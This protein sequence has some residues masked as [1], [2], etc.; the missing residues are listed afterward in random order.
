MSDDP[1]EQFRNQA[2]SIPVP[3]GDVVAVLSRGRRRL[4]RRHA[5]SV[6]STVAVLVIVAVAVLQISGN[7][8]RS[9]AASEPQLAVVARVTLRSSDG[10]PSGVG[11]DLTYGFGYIWALH[12]RTATLQRI[13]PNTNE[14]DRVITLD[15][16]SG[17]GAESW[18]VEAGFDRLWITNPR[19]G[20][21]IIVDP[22]SE[23][24]VARIRDVGRPL[25]VFVSKENLW[26][27]S[28]G[29][30]DEEVLYRVDSKSLE[31]T[32][33][34]GMGSECC[35]SG[36]VESNGYLWVS[37]SGVPYQPR[38]KT[39]DDSSPVFDLTNE[40]RKIDSATLTV[41]DTIP[42]EGDT[43]RPGD[44]TLGELAVAEG[45]LWVT[46]PDAGFVDRI[47]T[48]SGTIQ[49]IDLGSSMR[50]NELSYFEGKLWAW[51]LNGSLAVP[52]DP[53]SMKVGEASD[54]KEPLGVGPVEGA[55][56]LWAGSDSGEPDKADSVLRIDTIAPA[57]EPSPTETKETPTPE[58]EGNEV[59]EATTEQDKARVF[60]VRALAANGLLDPLGER[61][62]SFDFEN[63]TTRTSEG[64]WRVGFAAMDCAPRGNTQTCRGLSGED[65]EV[66][67]ALTDTFV[68]MQ[69]EGGSWE[70]LDIEGNMP[71]EERER[72]IGFS[73]AERDEPSHWEMLAVSTKSLEGE[74]EGF[75]ITVHPL[76][77]GPYPTKALGSVCTV[78][79]QDDQGKEIA[80]DVFYIEPPQREFE[81]TGGAMGLGIRG[82]EGAEE[83]DVSC[84]QYTGRGWE[85]AS[86]PEIVRAP[87][88]V[89]GVT[90][91]LVWR[92]DK[93]FTTGA[94]CRATLVDEDGNEVW[95]GSGIVRPLWRP[96]ELRDY[97][98]RAQVFVSSRGEPVDA[99]AIGQFNCESV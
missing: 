51:E 48:E 74:G 53:T 54:A 21:V 88:G 64:T 37:H 31:V 25:T 99:K 38:E 77:V 39:A 66:G 76:W 94:V 13:D 68:I 22:A 65:P 10:S 81:R 18:D 9:P 86:D 84:R 57:P 1:R 33:S 98:Y 43:F 2:K 49:S 67:N 35:V 97:P 91:E 4:R 80:Q 14:V 5:T 79:A 63:G 7:T 15:D 56:S 28:R 90:A 12:A 75:S 34:V 29:S 19:A 52:I 95:K 42:L 8:D 92:G 40:I 73:L 61:T 78:S 27:H 41:I 87:D 82:A 26:V 55:G 44:T 70:V 89:S 24:V 50:P 62:Y 23:E 71:D 6:L 17:K 32:G 46:R 36:I 47:D 69:L 60:A 16:K 83:A 72:V 93:G 96:N 11:R 85:I 59:I 30:L 20:E 58:P 3:P 45:Y